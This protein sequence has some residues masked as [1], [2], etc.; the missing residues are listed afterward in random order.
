[1]LAN[2]GTDNATYVNVTHNAAPSTLGGAP[3]SVGTTGFN[4]TSAYVQVPASLAD[5]GAYVSVSLTFKS[6]ATGRVLLSES[7]APVTSG[8]TTGAYR[9]VLYI[10]SSGKLL[11]GFAASGNPMSSTWSVNDGNWHNVVLTAAG[12][13]QVM[14]IDGVQAAV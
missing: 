8:T 1:M 4:G 2:E 9:P 10:G 3:S 14:Y 7:A 12:N 11:G 6:S 5:E 13:Q